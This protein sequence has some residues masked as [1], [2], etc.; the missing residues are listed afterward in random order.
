MADLHTDDTL[1]FEPD[2]GT[3][4]SDDDGTEPADDGRPATTDDD[5]YLADEK[6]DAPRGRIPSMIHY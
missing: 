5:T 3:P 6:R 1:S 4:G 2:D